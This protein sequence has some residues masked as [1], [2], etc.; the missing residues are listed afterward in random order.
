MAEKPT[1]IDGKRLQS[2]LLDW[3]DEN[4]RDLPWRIDKDPYKVWVSEIMLQQ[5]RVETVIPYYERFIRALP[6]VSDLAA[7]DDDA[8]LKL[9]EGLGY[10]RRATNLKKAAVLIV[11]QYGG[12]MPQEPS[13]L[14]QLPG[15]G[16]YTAGAIAS[17]AFG[18]RVSAS[19]GN[20][21]R[22]LARLTA[23]EESIDRQSVKNNLTASLEEWIPSGRPGDFNEALMDLGATICLPGG[24]P[25]CE[26]CPWS[27][28]CLARIR[29][30]EKQLPVRGA[31]K[32]RRIEKKTVMLLVS[33]GRVALQKRPGGGL[34]EHLWEFPG[35]DGWLASS[36]FSNLLEDLEISAS[37]IAPLGAARHIFSHVEWHMKGYR[38]D[39]LSAKDPDRWTWVTRDELLSTYP[40]PA[41]YRSYLD[42]WLQNF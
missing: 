2:E 10:Y 32:E 1:A 17:I 26:R 11:G 18:R 21:F 19:D 16:P 36:D 37:S 3:Y 42:E 5:T 28:D 23:C 9:W 7:V 31:K 8:L 13:L 34:L 27:A 22:I 4:K 20:V 39:V 30:L 6:S 29:G 41:A 14:A 35:A 12:C 38:V 15:I 40:V 25:L 24:V 33:K